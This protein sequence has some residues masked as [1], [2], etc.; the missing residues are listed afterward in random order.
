V[1]KKLTKHEISILDFELRS[2]K[3]LPLKGL[4]VYLDERDG[5][6]K[7]DFVNEDKQLTVDLI[8]GFG[9]NKYDD[10]AIEKQLKE[11]FLEEE[12]ETQE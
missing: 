11:Y 3:L 12:N 10:K 8:S 1:I 7:I 4:R 9:R 6:H 2:A 5:L